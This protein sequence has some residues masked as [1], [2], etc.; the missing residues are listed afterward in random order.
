MINSKIRIIFIW[1]TLFSIAMAFL[2]TSVAV[3]LRKLYY[4]GGF[5]FPL[6][7]MDKDIMIVE[8]FR[9]L[10]TL[11]MLL[12]AGF[13]A[14][15]N[16]TEKFGLFLYSFAVWDIFY[17][18]FLKVILDWPPSIVT[19]DILFLIPTT[20]VGPVIAPVIVS[21]AMIASAI[22]ISK[23]TSNNIQTK[24]NLTEWLLLIV[25]SIILVIGFTYDYIRFM[26][27]YFSFAEIF[28][29]SKIQ[30]LMAKALLYV[31]QSFPWLIFIAGMGLILF[32]MNL[33]Y[34]RNLKK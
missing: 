26:L 8:I 9:E 13:I 25:G 3:Y 14:G 4:P 31:P 21:V 34:L 28:T 19:W 7:I 12:G 2:E 6:K 16:R 5:D 20:W 11:I 30:A 23:S 10:A 33:F 15:R 17:Y 32:G 18:I 22:L 27:E 29:P 24:I 1:I